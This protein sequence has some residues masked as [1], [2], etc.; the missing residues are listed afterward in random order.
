MNHSDIGP[1]SCSR[2]L[3]CPA[4]VQLLKHNPMPASEWAEAGTAFHD[5]CEQAIKLGDKYT[6]S[7][8]D[9]LEY[10][11]AFKAKV[12]E[13]EELY[14]KDT[15]QSGIEEKVHLFSVSSDA[16]GT[17]DGFIGADFAPL[18]IWDIKS[19]YTYVSAE[20]NTQLMYYALA[21]IETFG[22][23]PSSV[24]LKIYQPTSEDRWREWQVPMAR[25]K[26]FEAELKAGVE[27]L[28][29]DAHVFIS[30]EH[31]KYCNKAA[32][33]SVN[34]DVAKV[35]D[36]ITLPSDI[37]NEQLA[38]M[39]EKEP[40]ITGFMKD[41]KNLAKQRLLDGDGKGLGKKLVKQYGNRVWTDEKKVSDIVNGLSLDAFNVK[42]KTPAVVEK[43]VKKTGDKDALK[44]LQGLMDK[45]DNGYKMVSDST[46][47]DSYAPQ[48]FGAI[49]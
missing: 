49:E 45:P 42:I 1:S 19:G 7:D 40:L 25:L 24:L 18:E 27:K 34:T 9:V 23:S 3:A 10:R 30:G 20:E 12:F 31:C 29:T 26:Q 32:C 28:K 16:Y 38:V 22:L 35:V 21:A 43:L 33:P 48:S 4:S 8:P 44:E 36:S 47:G 37:S 11:D 2:W 14:P 41:V 39:L 6:G 46:K 17:L 13:Y 15:I 5:E